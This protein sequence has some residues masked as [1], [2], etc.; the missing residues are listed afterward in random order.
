MRFVLGSDR[1]LLQF[2]DNGD[3]LARPRDAFFSVLI[4]KFNTNA[5]GQVTGYTLSTER[6]RNLRYTKVKIET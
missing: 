1:R 2:L 6:V 4:V 5:A 3:C